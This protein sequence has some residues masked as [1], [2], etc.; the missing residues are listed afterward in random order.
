MRIVIFLNKKAIIYSVYTLYIQ[1]YKKGKSM[2][3]FFSP[4]FAALTQP[5]YTHFAG[6]EKDTSQLMRD[7]SLTN[8]FE[9]YSVGTNTITGDKI[10]GLAN[11]NMSFEDRRFYEQNGYYASPTAAWIA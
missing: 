10:D 7:A 8:F 9:G 6:A 5:T 3:N 1:E 2:A 4:K 11:R